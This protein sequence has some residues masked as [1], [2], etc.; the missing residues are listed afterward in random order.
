M[1][2]SQEERCRYEALALISEQ[3]DPEMA[4]DLSP[5]SRHE[6]I[7]NP[8]INYSMTNTHNVLCTHTHIYNILDDIM[9][10]YLYVY[11]YIYMIYIYIHLR[12]CSNLI[13]AI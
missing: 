7:G 5:G 12:V 2:P 8:C 9:Y 3:D 6:W 1:C 11:I 13:N 10:T 4:L